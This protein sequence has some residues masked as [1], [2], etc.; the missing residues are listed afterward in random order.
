MTIPA[1]PPRRAD[2]FTATGEEPIRPG[3]WWRLMDPDHEIAGREWEPGVTPPEHGIVLLL[4]ETHVVDGE[5]HAV[6]LHGHPL[7]RM[8]RVKL[9]HDAFISAFAPCPDGEALRAAE[10]AAMMGRIQTIGASMSDMPGDEALIA[11]FPLKPK[12]SDPATGPSEPPGSAHVMQLPAALLPSGDVV[13]AQVRIERGI[14]LLEARS[15]WVRGKTDEMQ[16]GIKIVQSYQ[17]ERVA[18]TLAGI[19]GQR[20][21]AEDLLRNVHTMRL[22]LG[23]GVEVDTLL[24]GASAPA[25]EPLHLM[26]R[27]LY[28]DEEIF[29]S[30]VMDEGFHSGN[31]RD[32]LHL[33][34]SNPDLLERM[35]P[36]P[37]C[38]AIAR[39]R[40]KSREFETPK[41]LMEVFS[42]I[43]KDQQDKFVQILI[44]DG[45]NVHMVM[46]D[47][48]TSRAQR[49]FPSSRE[50]DAIFTDRSRYDWEKRAYQT[51]EI[52]PFD[53]EYSD[54]RG[55]HDQR[56]LFYKRFL[57]I[58]WGLQERK[59]V[60][61][62]FIAPDTN[63]LEE[64]THTRHFRFIHDEEN[65]LSDGLRPVSAWI[66]E[67]N[68][69]IRPGSRVL[70]QGNLIMT[71]DTAPTAYSSDRG[72]GGYER[73]RD[74][75][76]SN[77]VD[78][79]IVGRRGAELIV[80]LPTEQGYR[81]KKMNTP[82]R[83]R[84][85]DGTVVTSGAL[86]LD[87]AD[88]KTL[89]RYINSRQERASY[90]SWLALF[91][92]A[93]PIL[94]AREAADRA[95]IDRVIRTRPDL[96]G[97]LPDAVRILREG[98][99]GELGPDHD[100]RVVWLADRL[101][102]AA[103]LSLTDPGLQLRL[104]AN[105]DL[106]RIGAPRDPVS[107]EA[108]MP[109]LEATVL[110]SWSAKT[111]K[112]G[113]TRLIPFNHLPDPGEVVIGG[114]LGPAETAAARALAAPGL[115]DP[116]SHEA[117]RSLTTDIWS[118]EIKE[119]LGEVD[120]AEEGTLT[121][122]LDE[123]RDMNYATS[124]RHVV[125]PSLVM[126]VGVALLDGRNGGSNA[127]AL[128]LSLDP[129]MLA[130]RQG[131]ADL[132][133]HMCTR[134]YKKPDTGFERLRERSERQP[135]LSLQRFQMT[136]DTPFSNPRL[137]ERGWTFEDWD[138]V[139]HAPIRQEL[140]WRVQGPVQEIPAPGRVLPALA[141]SAMTRAHRDLEPVLK[142]IDG[143]ETGR[144]IAG[145]G[146]GPILDQVLRG[147]RPA[148]TG[149][150]ND[151]FAKTASEIEAP[152]EISREPE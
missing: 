100:V 52:T 7:L 108:R 84:E 127:W 102:R 88:A 4:S 141:V 126:P 103:D 106:V 85:A 114:S 94:E 72:T 75:Q 47:E 51:R 125:I 56:A 49:L 136:D 135:V 110:R 33:L 105:G 14:A 101:A 37:R 1:A 16:H 93:L 104:R 142:V 22:F 68:A 109:L 57:I 77:R 82:V 24:Q 89:R 9:L 25:S 60:F 65:V 69:W 132:V 46:A 53:I 99:K 124:Q 74:R 36:H 80:Q 26:Q 147:E 138:Q 140:D 50:I 111:P 91:M 44:R 143:A 11:L 96:S 130:F 58:L 13:E 90:L 73:H 112:E 115:R 78:E 86:C 28:L 43:E 31:M 92:A 70:V 150:I 38:V 121:A 87:R 17:E 151:A 3:T 10:L 107:L 134:L 30:S 61:G 45:E 19:S 23:E 54:K 149:P 79:L 113:I 123:A 120:R 137:L 97:T 21:M 71:P 12:T 76:A 119:F 152:E 62:P 146:I 27:M 18:Q 63:W 39:I 34:S 98:T 32:L 122:W 66:A 145:E 81:D 64:T 42:L 144:L 40:R 131:R 35:L 2:R 20:K 117:L 95:L 67:M 15:A 116:A 55:E 118:E 6:T 139:H 41:N 129:V 133:A 128:R 8:G 148:Q 83:L 59:G 48:E 29:V 5:I